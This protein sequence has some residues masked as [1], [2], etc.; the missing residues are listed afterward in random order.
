MKE[1]AE[2][3]AVLDKR[4]A[5]LESLEAISP[6]MHK[7][8][9]KII[10]KLQ[11]LDEVKKDISEIKASI[12]FMH[13]E[14]DDLKRSVNDLKQKSIESDS[15]IVNISAEN[16]KLR[17]EVLELRLKTEE[18]DFISRESNLVMR[19]I[20]E[21]PGEN[22]LE[23][24]LKISAKLQVPILAQD[25]AKIVRYKGNPGHRRNTIPQYGIVLLSFHAR[26]KRQEFYQAARKTKVSYADIGIASQTDYVFITEDLSRFL[27][28]LF[29]AARERK[30][31]LSWR[32]AWCKAGKVFMRQSDNSSPI[33]IKN[34]D[35]LKTLKA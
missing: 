16:S 25:I 9:D 10:L 32:Y 4:I 19:K 35:I 24:V 20:P 2:H 27:S 23:I 13:L 1:L 3:N 21:V 12:E 34:K 6:D 5:S 11:D 33:W 30:K 15:V 22:L 7:K 28:D 29:L 31:A 8:L 26:S 18:L 14:V 17:D